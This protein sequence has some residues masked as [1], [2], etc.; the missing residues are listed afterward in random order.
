[1]EDIARR[2]AD[3][4]MSGYTPR[5]LLFR[6]EDLGTDDLA[7]LADPMN[8]CFTD[9]E[10]RWLDTGTFQKDLSSVRD[11]ATYEH[12]SIM[13]GYGLT[14]QEFRAAIKR[15]SPL[16]PFSFYLA[17]MFKLATQWPIYVTKPNVRVRTQDTLV[18]RECRKSK[19]ETI[20]LRTTMRWMMDT[21]DVA[22][23]HIRTRHVHLGRVECGGVIVL[24]KRYSSVS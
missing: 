7:N 11:N 2:N 10:D 9:V 15:K 14:P 12:R 6:R 3:R 17:N 4:R 8:R 16:D 18:W 19:A 22:T 13:V 1:M 24:R 23:L 21:V 20:A 5:F